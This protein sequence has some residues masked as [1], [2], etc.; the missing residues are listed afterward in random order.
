M[1]VSDKERIAEPTLLSSSQE[2]PAPRSTADDALDA[3]SLTLSGFEFAQA[4][5]KAE[6]QLEIYSQRLSR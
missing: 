4:C 1:T 2:R 5:Q 6:I 3:L